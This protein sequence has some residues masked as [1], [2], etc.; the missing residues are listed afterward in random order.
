M[1]FFMVKRCT[2][3]PVVIRGSLPEVVVLR[4]VSL[5]SFARFR[6]PRSLHDRRARASGQV[7]AVIEV[8]A[9]CHRFAGR[10]SPWRM[11]KQATSEAPGRGSPQP[12]RSGAVRNGSRAAPDPLAGTPA[13]RGAQPGRP[14]GPAVRRGACGAA[15]T[16][17][18]GSFPADR[19]IRSAISALVS[20]S[21]TQANSSSSSDVRFASGSGGRAARSARRTSV[22]V[23]FDITMRPAAAV[24]MALTSSSSSMVC[25]TT[26]A[27]R[28]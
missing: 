24:R 22:N 23:S 18:C 8:H 3:R 11:S 1:P 9:I 26:P 17:S 25:G 21:P 19:C 6:P 4:M 5:L 20:P 7:T 28:L 15:G 14:P 10:R 2:G 16:R 12:R 13:R 27:A